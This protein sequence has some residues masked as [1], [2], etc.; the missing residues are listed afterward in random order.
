MTNKYL[1]KLAFVEKEAGLANQFKNI[2]TGN[3]ALK[4]K[5]K[6]MVT[7]G[8]DS[9]SDARVGRVGN[10]HAQRAAKVAP[11]EQAMKAD[12]KAW[13]NAGKETHKAKE[14]W[15]ESLLSRMPGAPRNAMEEAMH[16][17]LTDNLRKA[18]DVEHGL[19]KKFQG[20]AQAHDKAVYKG[21]HDDIRLGKIKAHDAERAEKV[22]EVLGTAKKV[23]IGAG[24]IGG[25][26][27][28]GAIINHYSKSKKK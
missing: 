4:S 11:K 24:V 6:R 19:K 18:E 17:S 20:S 8:K 12:L 25:I 3:M 7:L 15:S 13:E 2:A 10:I 23:G 9:V 14:P 16:K 22:R 1:E 26:T 27:G 5:V 21:I 28:T